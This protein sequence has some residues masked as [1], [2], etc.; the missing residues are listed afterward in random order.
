MTAGSIDVRFASGDSR[1]VSDALRVMEVAFDPKFGET[2]SGSQLTGFLALPGTLLGLAHDGDEPIGF[3]VSQTI[4]HEAELMLLGVS[5]LHRRKGVAKRLLGGLI[6]QLIEARGER[7][8]LE[9]RTDN[10]EA[11][12]L[13]TGFCFE[14]IGLRKAYYRNASGDCRD[15]VTMA[16]MIAAP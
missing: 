7:L 9:M 14:K 10:Q 4:G 5:P 2:W 3:C 6:N 16:R 11:F 13:Y 8:F 12:A 15:A 1:T